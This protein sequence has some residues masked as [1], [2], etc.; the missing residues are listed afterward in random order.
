M[1]H[2]KVEEGAKGAPLGC[3]ELSEAGG[4]LSTAGGAGAA[5]SA[6]G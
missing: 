4:V 6:G 1:F 5:E 2:G 3:R